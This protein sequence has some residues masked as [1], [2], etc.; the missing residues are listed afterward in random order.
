MGEDSLER[1]KRAYELYGSGD[2]DAMLELFAEDVEIYVA[3]Q[4]MRIEPLSM[5]AALEHLAERAGGRRKV[6]VLGD[7]A[8]LG[9]GAPA[10][11]RE[12]GAAAS[13]AGRSWPERCSRSRTSSRCS[14]TS[15]PAAGFST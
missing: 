3:P 2:F 4:E 15:T 13:R 11:H 9:P 10:Y 1:C 5:T 7:M 8:E 14:W 6:A 12:V